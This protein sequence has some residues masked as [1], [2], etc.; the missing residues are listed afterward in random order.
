MLENHD[1]QSA[2]STNVE[3]ND[4]N[5]KNL[6]E[7]MKNSANTSPIKEEQSSNNLKGTIPSIEEE[8]APSENTNLSM[9]AEIQKKEALYSQKTEKM[10]QTHDK[11]IINNKNPELDKIELEN[12]K[13]IIKENEI[14]INGADIQN[15]NIEKSISDYSLDELLNDI[16]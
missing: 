5:D 16:K 2:V 8:K 11:D 6:N 13:D 3:N 14:K 9:D 15:D 10:Q 7:V 4:N 1:D 12:E